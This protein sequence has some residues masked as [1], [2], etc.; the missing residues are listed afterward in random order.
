MSSEL[1]ASG[2]CNAECARAVLGGVRV[3]MRL[4]VQSASWWLAGFLGTLAVAGLLW[5]GWDRIMDW[6]ER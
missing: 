4:F 2:R 5:L 3:V 6:W 1:R